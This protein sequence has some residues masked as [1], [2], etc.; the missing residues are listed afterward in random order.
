MLQTEFDGTCDVYGRGYH[1]IDSKLEGLR[2]YMF[3]I[4]IE[5]S[6]HGMYMTEKLMD[7]AVVGVVPVYWGS[8][9]ATSL[10]KDGILPWDTLDDLRHILDRLSPALYLNMRPRLQRNLQVAR[11]YAPPEQ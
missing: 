11:H 4:V 7:A 2:D 6:R 9:F 1:P 10:F 5:K 3:T 8:T